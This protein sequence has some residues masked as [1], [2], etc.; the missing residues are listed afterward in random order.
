MSL[1]RQAIARLRRVPGAVGEWA[2]GQTAL[3][4]I[5]ALRLLPMETALNVADGF[6]RR[7]GPLVGRHKVALENLRLAFPEKSDAEVRQIA[8]DMWGHM[9]R[10]AG[11]YL[12]LDQ[13]FDFDPETKRGKRIEVDGEPNFLSIAGEPDR[14]HIIFTGHLGNFE[15]LPVAG[16]AFGMPV[17]SMF[18]PPN[19]RY[20]ADYIYRTRTGAMGGLLASRMGASFE[21]A[22]ILEANGNIGVLVDQK[23]SNGVP[24]TFFGRPCETSP[25][26]AKLA[27]N[28]QCDVYP[29]RCVRL[30]GTRFR[31]IM[32]APL[33]LPRAADG[34]VDIAATTQ[35]LNDIV[36]RWI[37]EDPAQWMWFHKRWRL[38]GGSRSRSMQAR[39]KR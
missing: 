7:F 14:P 22:R 28:F 2:F 15:L 26:L 19:N 36:E 20:I 33:A 23:F 32:E 34:R 35:M 16:M 1:A 39:H 4:A 13:I 24:T 5:R 10:L 21:L 6:A 30:P 3:V 17:T 29:T 8:L 18:R 27:R 37:R 9:A 31:L 11:E 12:F 38:T 25:L